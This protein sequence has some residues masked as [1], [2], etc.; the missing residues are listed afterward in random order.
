[1]FLGEYRYMYYLKILGNPKIISAH[2]MGS[3]TFHS[4]IPPQTGLLELCYVS[5]GSIPVKY[6]D[7]FV[8]QKKYHLSVNPRSRETKV[9]IPHFHI[10][11]S[12]LAQMDF[13]LLDTPTAD[14]IA[15]PPNIPFSAHGK[16]H[17]LID[18]I[19]RTHTL[20][21][22]NH[23]AT[24]GMFLH[25][26]SL[27][28]ANNTLSTAGAFTRPQNKYVT[29]AKEYVFA[30]LSSPVSQSEIAR[31]L[32]ITP[33]YLCSVFKK[34]EGEP[35]VTYVN[36]VKL[37]AIRS[38]MLKEGLTLATASEQCGYRDPNYVSRLFQKY[39]GESITKNISKF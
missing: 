8:L 10:H 6:G 16:A 7:E 2:S 29:H 17:A 21:P 4:V 39:Y 5:E 20:A 23:L 22:Q 34:V 31:H 28:D 13:E 35:L 15:L 11:H 3:A 24:C 27:C 26:L 33:E 19:I 37:N 38:L 9:E 32:G 14:T 1:M 30:H 18:E 25:L 12:V 36:R